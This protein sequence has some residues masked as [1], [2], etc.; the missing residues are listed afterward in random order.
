MMESKPLPSQNPADEREKVQSA[1]IEMRRR[2]PFLQNVPIVYMPEIDPGKNTSYAAFYMD[3]FPDVITM[4]E[5]AGG[6]YGIQKTDVSTWQMSYMFSKLLAEKKICFSDFLF[7]LSGTPPKEL[8]QMLKDQAHRYVWDFDEAKGT[9]KQT[10]K[11]GGKQ[12]DLLIA[13]MMV[14]VYRQLFIEKAK[15]FKPYKDFL[16]KAGVANQNNR[17]FMSG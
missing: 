3:D 5:A 2:V 12:D 7:S 11:K 13:T 8:I 16:E 9:F 10:G 15:T 17:Y 14:P 1:V 4:R 6:N